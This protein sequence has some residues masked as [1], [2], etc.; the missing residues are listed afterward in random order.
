MAAANPK[1]TLSHSLEESLAPINVWRRK[2]RT[3]SGRDRNICPH[4]RKLSDK[5]ALWHGSK[6]AWLTPVK[7]SCP[8]IGQPILGSAGDSAMTCEV[9]LMNKHGVALAADSAVTLGQGQKIYHT[10]DKLFQISPSVPV[11]IMTYGSAE[12]MGMPWEIVIKS[13]AQQLAGR[14][15]ERLEQYA[16]DFLRFIELS[17]LFFSE[18]LQRTDFQATVR[19]YWNFVLLKPLIEKLEQEPN[20]PAKRASQLLSDLLKED[21]DTW[22]KYPAL[23]HLGSEYGDRVVAEYRTILDE[24]DAEVF[25]ELELSKAVHQRLRTTAKYMYAQKWFG[26][27]DLSG[28]V[29][30]GMGEAEAFP[31][32]IE[33]NVGTIAAG[34]LRFVKIN[35]ARV[36]R[37]DSAIVV[38][39][40][41]REMIDLFYDGIFPTLR[42]K[43]GEIIAGC[44]S[45][46]FLKPGSKLAPKQVEKIENNVQKALENEIR[47]EYQ[48]PLM[49]ALDALPRHDLA[50]MAESLISLTALRARM[51]AG[52]AE[53]VGG[54]IDVA[55]LSKGEGFVWIKRKNVVRADVDG[56]TTIGFQRP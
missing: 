9:A 44:I 12:M 14:K 16:E 46:E 6:G 13:Y 50:T 49:S 45:S 53:T 28:I 29:V 2:I 48:R 15:F 30:A 18:A 27:G 4:P 52:E 8:L 43:L 34:R 33:Y 38:P 32:L 37:E 19:G 21:H 7:P 1:L 10:A 25:G 11:A 39:L 26:P 51:T 31:I 17:T 42:D 5:L 35:E 54:P 56:F 20:D 23:E 22:Q 36:S 24:L 47:T 40:A 3:K 55:I 41:Q